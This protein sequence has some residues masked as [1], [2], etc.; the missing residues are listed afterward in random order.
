M[1]PKRPVTGPKLTVA[2]RQA[3]LQFA[4]TNLN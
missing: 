1:T 3:R 2:H 4:R